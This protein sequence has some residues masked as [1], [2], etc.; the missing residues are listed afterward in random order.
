MALHWRGLPAQAAVPEI[1]S[2]AVEAWQPLAD[3]GSVEL[4][5]FDG[6]LELRAL[7]HN[8]HHAVKTVLSETPG[9]SVVAYLGD[10][11]TDEDAFAAVKPR[12]LA[13][14]V[15]A[16]AAR[17]PR[18]PVDPAAGRAG[19]ISRALAGRAQRSGT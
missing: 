4:L 18:R 9:D 14:L 13:V 6:G 8:K 3:G 15:R 11:I 16:R 7:G 5:D 19:R 2:A 12:G 17:D 1:R 10:D